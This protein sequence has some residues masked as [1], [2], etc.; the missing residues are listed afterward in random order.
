MSRPRVLILSFSPIDRDPR[1]LRQVHL[2]SAEYDVITCGYGPAPDGVTGHIRVPDALQQW[3]TRRFALGGLLA[4]RRFERLYFG[5][6][7]TR[8][9]Q[10]EVA[11]RGGLDA[12]VANDALAA[13]VAASLGAPFHS[14]LHEYAPRQG[15][16]R[17][18]WRL[19]IRPLM[20]WACRRYVT[21]SASQTTVAQGIAAEYSRVYGLAPTVVPNATSHRPDLSPTPVRTPIRLVHIGVAGRARRLEVMARAVAAVN[22]R[23]PGRVTFDLILAAGERDYIRELTSYAEQ[24]DVEGVRVLPPVEFTQIVPT[25][26]RYDVGIFVCPP[27]TFNLAHALPNKFF[28]FIQA[29]L[30]IIVGPSVEM[31]PLV[32][33]HSLGVVTDDFDEHSVAAAIERLT[34]EDVERYKRAAHVAAPQ[35]GAETLSQPWLEAV[36]ALSE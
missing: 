24:P 30:A 33:E 35:L 16:H 19:L 25:L 34:T 31:A 3:R 28:E 32:D 11:R 17:A 9:V 27:T 13:P 22:R 2:L 5:A 29:R 15:E 21:R 36:R 20:D 7:R 14:D 12:I 4:A 1:V 23:H 6:E 8:F 26:H 10:D 18:Q